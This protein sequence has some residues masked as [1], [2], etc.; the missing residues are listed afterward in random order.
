MFPRRGTRAFAPIFVLAMTLAS[1]GLLRG[2]GTGGLTA[3]EPESSAIEWTMQVVPKDG[4]IRVLHHGVPIISSGSKFWG[5]DWAWAGLDLRLE[6][7]GRG[8]YRFSGDV[9]SLKLELA[10]LVQPTAPNVL[11]LDFDLRPQEANPKVIGGGL[12][13]SLKLDSPTFK[14]RPAA[15][16]LLPERKGWRWPVGPGKAITFRIEGGSPKVYFEGGNKNTIRVF[17]LAGKIE[18]GTTHFRVTLEL[19]EDGR[20]RPADVERYS[21]ATPDSWFKGAMLPNTS[22]VDL[23]FLNRDDRPAGRRGP[24]RA[25][26]ERLVFGDGTPA[27]FWGGNL[28]AYSL[29]ATPRQDIPRHAHRMAQ[30]GFNLMRIHHHDSKWVG[31]NI[32]G[33]EGASTRALDPRTLDS[34]DWWVKCLED[35][36]IYV[37]LDLHVGRRIQPGDGVTHGADELTKRWGDLKILNYYNDDIQDLMIEFQH[38]YLGHRNRYTKKTYAEDPGVVAI[39]LTNENDLTFHGGHLMLSQK[40]F[41]YH[42]ARWKAGCDRVCPEIQPLHGEDPADLDPGPEQD[43]LPRRR[44]RVQ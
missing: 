1:P 36:G 10:G 2:Q 14:D 29:F 18:R 16:E 27:R 40:E 19:P 34:I 7:L 28:A 9:K 38:A 22:P 41:P 33:K 5:K 44:A 24:I 32:F 26:G 35:E 31:T 30:L 12:E 37:W 4:S 20:L 13:W 6:P 15:P 21:P 17:F 43:V 3:D 8:K 11:Q 25:E 42:S 39:L 23:S